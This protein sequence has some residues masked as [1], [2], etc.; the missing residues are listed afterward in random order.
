[1]L[2]VLVTLI[3]SLYFG[4]DLVRRDRFTKNANLFINNEA[5]FQ[6]DYLLSKKID[7]K[8]REITL[9]FGGKQISTQEIEQ[10]STRLNNYQLDKTTLTINQGF[11]YLNEDK[12][13][14]HND[15]LARLTVALAEKEKQQDSLQN[16]LDSITG[17]ELK[18]RQIFAELKTQYPGIDSAVIQPG[19]VYADSNKVKSG[20][21]VI[22]NTRSNLTDAE[23]LKLENWLRVRL[24]R[25]DVRLIIQP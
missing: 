18:N 9:V 3:P 5:H 8:S 23:R 4:Y 2:V 16:L 13:A 22:L 12:D 17:L 7:P 25:S 20:Y 11:A 1:W 21:L 24:R 15:Q 19:N 6:N 10:L 14:L